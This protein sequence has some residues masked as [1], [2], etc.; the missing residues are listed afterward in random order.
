MTL[1]LSLGSNLGDREATINK[2]VELLSERIGG[3]LKRSSFY[4]SPSW[5]YVSEHEFC[6]ICASFE[7]A[8][9]PY[10]VLTI[11][12]EIEREL[13]RRRIAYA[14]VAPPTAAILTGDD[15][16]GNLQEGKHYEDRPIDIDIIKMGDIQMTSPTLTIPH[17]LYRQREFVTIPLSELE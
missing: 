10:E 3:L 4:Y 11:T 7:T 9:D 12:Q 14:E 5:G 15:S 1:Y 8:L 16:R 2:A 17:P 13:G 6:N